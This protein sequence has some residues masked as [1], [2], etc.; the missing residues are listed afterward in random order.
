VGLA[1]L[2]QEMRELPEHYRYGR[3][4][5]VLGMLLELGGVPQSLAVGGRCEVL[6]RENRRVACEQ[7]REVRADLADGYAELAKLLEGGKA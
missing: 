5:G 7:P 2:L 4:T 1:T 3:V 6:S